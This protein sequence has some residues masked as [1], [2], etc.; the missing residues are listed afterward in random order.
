MFDA[1]FLPL[2]QPLEKDRFVINKSRYDS[3]DSYLSC[4]VYSDIDLVYDK[5]L[6]RQLIDGGNFHMRPV[7]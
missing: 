5:D 4:D 3:I 6:Y 1:Y 7:K 2:P